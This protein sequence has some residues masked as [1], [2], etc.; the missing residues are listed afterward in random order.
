MFVTGST[1]SHRRIAR[2][3]AQVLI[4]G[5]WELEDLARRGGLAL[6]R[7]PRWLRP[8]L[9]RLHLALGT[10]PRPTAHRVAAFLLGDPRFRQGC[11]TETL[12]IEPVSRVR[13][14]MWSAPAVPVWPVPVLTTPTE[15]AAFLD[16]TPGEL[17]WFANLQNRD[18]VVAEGPLRHYVWEWVPK[19]LGAARLI[20]APK[21]RL[22]ALQ[23]RLLDTLL[24]AIPPHDAAHGFRP[25]RS[26]RSFAEP[27]AGR[28]VVLKMDL[29][30][31]F[32]SVT[33]T[34]VTAIFRTIGYPEAVARRLAGLCT[35]SAP[36][37]VWSTPT[38]PSGGPET[39]RLRRMYAEPHLPQGAPTS[40][41]LANLAA[42][43]LDARLSALAG[44]AGAGYTRYAD[45]LAFSGGRDFARGLA[46]FA[47]HI[48]AVALEEGFAINHH[49]TRNMRQGTRQ[50][51]AGVVV[52]ARPNV[53]RAE[54]D[55]L[56]A[57]LWN[58][59]IHGPETQNREGVAD[60]RAHLLGR[61]SHVA[62]IHPDRG[63]K[64]RTLFERIDW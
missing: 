41:A 11:A 58:C 13:P 26:V 36:A 46:R 54:Y 64:L 48:G 40:P 15:L 2:G 62:M 24:A 7:R 52:N 44:A 9:R 56:K 18:T 53:P 14:V 33:A 32:P 63:G 23:R 37:A 20:E 21:P 57:T 59:V 34:R 45:D 31:F 10:H 16:V 25:G 12:T 51:L 19:R 38:A 30:D 49:K 17:E 3:L 22:K 60:F 39:W 55:R 42:Y 27:H 29:R 5:P 1:S 35:H 61:I 47:A 50:R 6:G 43:R 28:I 4:E 8:L